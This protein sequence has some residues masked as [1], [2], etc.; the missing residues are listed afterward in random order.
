MGVL[1][2]LQDKSANHEQRLYALEQHPSGAYLHKRQDALREEYLT[3]VAEHE[4]LGRRLH[5]MESESNQAQHGELL[6]LGRRLLKVEDLGEAVSRLSADLSTQHQEALAE[7][8]K[9]KEALLL[10][11]ATGLE[12][13]RGELTTLKAWRD[14]QGAG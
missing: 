9:T 8:E 2:D 7:T 3:L 14:R 4:A 10:T 1:E 6:A 12:I 5:V 13:Q 11:F